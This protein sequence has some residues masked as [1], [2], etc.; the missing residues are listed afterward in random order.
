MTN[1][2]Q[3]IPL[4]VRIV[5]LRITF[6]SLVCVLSLLVLRRLAHPGSV[7]SRSRSRFRS[8]SP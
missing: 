5:M 8:R 7:I 6:L 3:Y 2:V 4:I 1:I